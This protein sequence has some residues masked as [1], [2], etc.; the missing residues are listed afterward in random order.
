MISAY[1]EYEIFHKTTLIKRLRDRHR[2][3]AATHGY[4][5]LYKDLLNQQL[6]APPAEQNHDLLEKAFQKRD[7]LCQ[8]IEE[9]LSI[10][11]ALE[12]FA[13]YRP[14]ESFDK[15]IRSSQN[16]IIEACASLI[17]NIIFFCE[18]DTFPHPPTIF[19]LHNH[20]VYAVT[21]LYR[22]FQPDSLSEFVNK[23][24]APICLQEH[25]HSVLV[26]IAATVHFCERPENREGISDKEL[27]LAS[28]YVFLSSLR[29]KNLTV[30]LE[31]ITQQLSPLNPSL[32]II[33][34]YGRC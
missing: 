17:N 22:L 8:S 16:A 10:L 21:I 32:Y 20:L 12:Q 25:I 15:K 5:K 2:H 19:S 27:W 13:Q 31:Y 18:M 26:S 11:Q 28:Q 34:E 4:D 14:E 3:Y 33:Y 9:K 7:Q 29:R 6:E 1:R 30:I 23:G 24:L